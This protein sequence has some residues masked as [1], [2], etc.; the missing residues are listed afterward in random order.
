MSPAVVKALI[1]GN[2]YDSQEDNASI[3]SSG[4]ESEVET[5]KSTKNK[6]KKKSHPKRKASAL[7]AMST[8]GSSAGRKRRTV[9]SLKRQFVQD[10]EEATKAKKSRRSKIVAASSD[11]D[12]SESK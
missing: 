4:S 8:G 10:V 9:G 1:S 2:R 12:T 3:S 5:K 7:R 11:S 6:K